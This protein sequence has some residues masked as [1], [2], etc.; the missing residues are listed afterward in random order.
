MN[1]PTDPHA[2]RD[3]I[4]AA[5]DAPSIFRAEA[6]VIRHAIL[7]LRRIMEGRSSELCAVADNA[8][9]YAETALL[10]MAII[11]ARQRQGLSVHWA[12]GQVGICGRWVDRHIVTIHHTLRLRFL[13]D[14][15]GRFTN[16]F[17]EIEWHHEQS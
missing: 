5:R 1:E 10:F 8:V 13:H 12:R 14:L 17:A 4:Q 2:L 6:L 15:R 9:R 7:D 11:E 3:L 16:I